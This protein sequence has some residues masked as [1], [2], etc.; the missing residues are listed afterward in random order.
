MPKPKYR[1]KKAP[2]RVVALPEPRTCQ[3]SRPEHPDVS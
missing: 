1:K 3:D 2:K